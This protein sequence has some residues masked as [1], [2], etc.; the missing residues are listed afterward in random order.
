MSEMKHRT[1]WKTSGGVAGLLILF[2][3]IVAANVILGNLRMRADL[4]KE[5]LY[6]LSPGTKSF[7]KKLDQPVTLKLFF[8]G[9]APEVPMY[10][11]N[12]AKQV[13]DLLKEYKLAG[14]G[15]VAVEMYDPTPDSD[16]EEWAQRY[17]ISGQSM[18][19][20]GP[21]I[22]FGLA[23]SA[24]KAEG[25]IAF[26]D[27]RAD[28]LLEFNITRLISRTVKPEKPQ[29]GVISSLPVLGDSQ[30]MPFGQSRRP[31]SWLAFKD[32]Q[33]DYS[34]RN[35]SADVE[36]IDKE[37]QTLVLVHPKDLSDKTLYAIDQFVLRGG[38]LIA[39]LDP[40]CVTELESAQQQP[41]QRPDSSS[42]LEKLLTAWGVGYE[43]NKVVADPR[44]VTRLR[45][46][47]GQTD[48]SLVFLSLTGQNCEKDDILTAQLASVMLP[49]AGS[50]TDK[51]KGL[52]FKPLIKASPLAG[53][54]D[55]MTAQYGGATLRRDLKPCATPPVLAARLTGKFKTAFPDG[56]PKGEAGSEEKKETPKV[57]DGHF[58]E[59][60]SSVI[61]VG[62]VDM[63]AD[64][65]CVEEL[66]F[67]GAQAFRPLNN[68]LTLFGNALEQLSGSSDLIGIR[69]RGSFDRP[70]ERVT[71][72]EEKA[73]SEWQEREKD[74]ETKLQEAR[75]QL[76]QL[77]M[78]KDQSQKFILSADQKAAIE[79]FRGEEIRINQE[80]KEVRKNLRR[81]IEE[82]GLKV[83]IL[84]IALM[85]ALV[86]LAG[87]GF[88]LYRRRKQ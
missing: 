62:D 32:L 57:D 9:S 11:K 60:E 55:A 63:L 64:R 27:P 84:N 45:T 1:F 83:K 71:E 22:F 40:F 26:L 47:N 53:L 77:Q 48:E 31:Q 30:Q 2:A 21:Q 7:L 36:S 25:A 6:T 46:Q 4:T 12:Y 41:F 56:K 44:A 87:I 52:T 74:L 86:C 72:L 38:R 8:S 43:A 76:S 68:N 58:T 15:N 10:L 16:A 75:Q 17:G 69:S 39:F 59:G 13:Q 42:N 33:E 14:G 66:N 80:L 70:F 73:Q 5:K 28:N 29:V 88:G 85:P 49:F 82:L 54:V 65:F 23:A 61:L 37:L 79:R 3:V 78:Q 19:L 18:G 51:T 67:F 35:I 24:G 50:F 20:G 81:D 34:I